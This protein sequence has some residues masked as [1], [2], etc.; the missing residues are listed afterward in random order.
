[1]TK[2]DAIVL[3]LTG[4]LPDDERDFLIYYRRS[5]DYKLTDYV[6]FCRIRNRYLSSAPAPPTYCLP[7][8]PSDFPF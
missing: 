2:E 8:D 3:L 4:E 6:R 1:M 7:D 5:K